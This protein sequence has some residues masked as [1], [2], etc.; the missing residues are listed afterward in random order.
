[1]GNNLVSCSKDKTSGLSKRQGNWLDESLSDSPS[2]EVQFNSTEDPNSVQEPVSF[3]EEAFQQVCLLSESGVGSTIEFIFENHPD[4]LNVL[5]HR[6]SSYLG[7]TK[8]ELTPLQLAATCGHIDVVKTLL[9]YPTIDANIADPTFYMTA[10][11][12]AV[13]AGETPTVEVLCKD[14]NIKSDLKTIEGKT[15]LH[16]AVENEYVN[17]VE[18]ILR[19]HPNED[20]RTRDINGNTVFHLA[21][22]RPNVRIMSLLANHASLVHMYHD[23]FRANGTGTS[24]GSTAEGSEKPGRQILMV[25]FFIFLLI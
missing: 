3:D 21:A 10:L 7:N 25:S 8:M 22:Y 14:P 18:T 2:G 24:P 12:L 9:K 11:H 13:V 16:L 17:I 1:M 23:K 4:V 20:F 19:L 6:R 15:A 5:N